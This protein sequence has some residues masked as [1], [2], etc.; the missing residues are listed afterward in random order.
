MTILKQARKNIEWLKVS[1]LLFDSQNF[2]LPEDAQG[3]HQNEVLEILDQGFRLLQIGESL[4]DNGYFIEEPLVV[5]P[6]PH[7]KYIVVEGN[8]RLAALKLLLEKD[9][10]SLSKDSDAWEALAKRLKEDL[11]EVPVVKH[12][13]RDELIPVLGY[14]HIAGIEMWD[15]L[16][17]AI[18]ISGLV[19]QKGKSADFAE[20]AREI[21][22]R[23][24]FV[25][26]QYITH[27]TYLQARDVFHIDVSELEKT[28]SVFYRAITG[29]PRI[30]QFIGLSKSKSPWALKRPV[31]PRMADA[32]V[33]LIGY[34]HGTEK[35]EPVITDS[36]QLTKLGEV[37]A[38]KR[39][40]NNLRVNRKLERAHELSIDEMQ[41]LLE[42]LALASDCLDET[43]K[44][45]HRHK[46]SRRVK[47]MVRRC[48]QTMQQIAKHFPDLQR[49]LEGM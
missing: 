1:Q 9:L 29:N 30:A 11:S 24:D 4:A 2:R 21:G 25:R 37:L 43:L 28:Y 22:K 16:A 18:F 44:Y 17:K 7:D 5:I 49:D 15:P 46:S 36:R 6:G 33:E 26:K 32:L 31:P 38:S 42:N 12:R 14:R 40:L 23:S 45:A 8:R 3:S 41:R 34:I 13:S 20:I 27:R 39:A 35:V 47:E 10:R 48:L 19:D